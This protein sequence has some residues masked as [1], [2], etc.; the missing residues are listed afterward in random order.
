MLQSMG[1]QKVGHHSRTEQKKEILSHA[2]TGMTLKDIMLTEAIQL[3][4]DNPVT[5]RQIMNGN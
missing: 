1:L 4:K 2:T 3:Q 5:E